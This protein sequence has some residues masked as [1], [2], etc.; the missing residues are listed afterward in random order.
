M[1]TL[2]GDES[3]N[4]PPDEWLDRFPTPT[5][6]SRK[7]VTIDDMLDNLP[8]GSGRPV[9]AN[10]GKYRPNS[11]RSLEACLVLGIDPKELIYHPLE[12]FASQGLTMDLQKMKYEKFESLRQ[13]RLK[14]LSAERAKISATDVNKTWGSPSTS[15]NQILDSLQSSD[16]IERE[17]KRLEVVQRRQQKELEQLLNY[18]KRR[19]ELKEQAEK[20]MKEQ[21]RRMI[22][23]KQL[24]EKR[25][26]EWQVAMRERELQ[27]AKEEARL[28]Q[29]AKALASQKYREE[30]ASNQR[31]Q[32]REKRR[33]Y[34]AHLREQE[35]IAKAEYHR[36]Q[37]ESILKEQQELITRKQEEVRLRDEER[38]IAQEKL[39]KERQL[40]NEVKRKKAEERLQRALD[41]N[42]KMLI[43]KRLEYEE[44]QEL[45]A[46]R[47][48]E[49]E[50]KMKEAEERRIK[51]ELAKQRIREE[52]FMEAQKREEDRVKNI[53][54]KQ[55]EAEERLAIVK[56]KQLQK[57]LQ[58]S[59]SKH[60]L[61]AEKKTRVQSMKRAQAYKRKQMLEK[62][63]SDTERAQ[64]LKLA[65][66]QL[67]EKRKTANM[68]ATFER[69]MIYEV[70]EKIQSGKN[71]AN[72]GSGELSVESLKAAAR[73]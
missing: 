33:Q 39:K 55:R 43:H 37:T 66:E 17:K 5:K 2:L 71:L 18:E 23:Q 35:R 60:L 1:A 53:I 4:L 40:L 15:A 22:A 14:K 34:E 11:P 26:T 45:N 42:R 16:M 6:N 65:K 13:D 7:K 46:K 28:E 27:R 52:K 20:K 41:A 9:S 44:K 47:K 50:I 67:Q 73:K 61:A 64:S 31:E 24:R 36:K 69:Q 32:E 59:M 63:K 49:R 62:I 70:M 56:E 21:E 57:S 48:T 10:A 51:N 30:L 8:D 38:Q 58:R 68:Q 29:E 72:T 25:E 3:L 54:R 19:Q 12:F